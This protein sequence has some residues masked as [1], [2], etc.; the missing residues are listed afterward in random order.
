MQALLQ[1]LRSG[2]R[3]L[4]KEPGYTLIVVM[5]LSLGIGANTAI[6]SVVNAVL[7][8]P[9]PGFE[10]GRVVVLF[11]KTADGDQGGVHGEHIRD[12]RTQT[13]VFER[14][15]AGND[16]PFTLT[17]VDPPESVSAAIVTP[18]YFTIYRIQAAYGRLFLPEEEKPGRGRVAVLDFDFWQRRFVGDQGIVGRQIKLNQ[19]DYT[20]VG[21]APQGFHPLGR[22]HYWL[23]GYQRVGRQ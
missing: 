8:R 10:T 15:E 19:E 2:A 7:F 13:T 20:V 4:A 18:G 17:G 21:I 1:D 9:M 14:I 22:G 5:I 16:L 23:V 12:W 3:T 6:F 11:T